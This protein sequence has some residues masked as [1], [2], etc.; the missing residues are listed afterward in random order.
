MPSSVLLIGQVAVQGLVGLESGTTQMEG[1]LIFKVLMR[2]STEIEEIELCVLIELEMYL[3]LRDAIVVK[4]LMSLGPHR[5]YTSALLVRHFTLLMA[6][7]LPG[8]L[9]YEDQL[10]MFACNS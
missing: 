6:S 9:F 10:T 5:I 2:T 3:P 8:S 1:E 4:F 7:T